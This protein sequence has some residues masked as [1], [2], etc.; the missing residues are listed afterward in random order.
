MWKLQ[1][2]TPRATNMQDVARDDRQGDHED[3]VHTDKQQPIWIQ[4]W[5]IDNRRNY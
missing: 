4:R 2:N 3:H 5:N 1:T